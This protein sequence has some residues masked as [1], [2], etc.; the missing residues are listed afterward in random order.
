[1]IANIHKYDCIEYTNED[2]ILVG[3]ILMDGQ[4]FMYAE[5]VDDCIT[6]STEL[7]DVQKFLN[8]VETFMDAEA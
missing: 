4:K 7:T 2:D 6:D 3:R 1:M 5:I 8:E